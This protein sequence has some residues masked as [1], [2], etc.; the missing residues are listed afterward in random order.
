MTPRASWRRLIFS[1]IAYVLW[2]PLPLAGLA[3]AG[4]VSAARPRAQRPWVAAAIVGALSAGFLLGATGLLG[5][6]VAAFA[7][8][9]TA[10]F[11][12]GAL[13]APTT[14]LRQGLR[15]TALAGSVTVILARLI[16]G[17][18]WWMDL[19]WQSTHEARIM[20]R[21][22]L[23]LLPEADR[24][25]DGVI[26]F[27]SATIPATLALQ[28]LAGLALAWQWHVAVCDEPLGAPVGP[29]REFRIDDAWVWAVVATLIVWLVP[30]LASLKTMAL[31]V[32]VVLGALYLV[33]G[34]AIVSVFAGVVGISTGALVAVAIVAVVLT[35]PLLLL[36]PGLWTLGVT[37]T[38][39]EFRR[40]LQS[41]G[42][43]HAK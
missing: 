6:F 42:R 5:G 21:P 35:V 1:S 20:A 7:V 26:A 39:F 29:F 33:R 11:V 40:R 10:A 31:N 36:V 2:A 17:A 16:W 43:P 12:G 38:W 34:A 3:F 18:T 13:V 37:D 15:A 4:L 24:V 23:A 30:R 8:L 28:A 14:V 22:L 25:I 41:Q 27:T 19:Q 32:A 9:L